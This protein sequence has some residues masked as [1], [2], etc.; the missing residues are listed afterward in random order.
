[1]EKTVK[2]TKVDVLGAV[3]VMI[4]DLVSVDAEVSYEVGGK[5]VTAQD[6]M[7]YCASTKAQLAAKADKA[8]ERAAEKKAE[9]DALREKVLEALTDEFQTREQIFKGFAEDE[10]LTVAKIGARLTQL[11]KAGLAVKEEQKTVTGKKVVY[12]KA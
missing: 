10:T 11:A 9:G 6:I 3:E 7:D 8:K 2:I 5:V 4:K 1:M 12:K